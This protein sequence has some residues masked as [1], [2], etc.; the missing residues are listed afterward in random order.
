M[1][2]FL[3]YASLFLFCFLSASRDIYSE[4]VFKGPTE[5]D[6]IFAVFI[7]S[8]VTQIVALIVSVSDKIVRTFPNVVIRPRVS[9]TLVDLLYANIFTM[10]A[11]ITY[12]LAIRTS[13]GASLNAFVDYGC[14]PI[15]TGLVGG[16]LLKEPLQWHFGVASFISIIGVFILVERQG[17][18]LWNFS[19]VGFALAIVSCLCSVIYRISFKRLLQKQVK[20]ASIVFLRLIG[21]SVAAGLWL[22]FYGEKSYDVDDILSLVLTGVLGFAAPL[23]L[24]LYVLQR[25]SISRFGLFLFALPA[26]IYIEAVAFGLKQF[27]I[28]DCGAALMIFL[29]IWFHETGREKTSTLAHPSSTP[30]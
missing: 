21:T 5:V 23:F 30:R 11:F 10:G 28:I 9:E 15:L 29:G 26:I 16:V 8:I 4:R 3:L 27:S 17:Q 19:N 1:N 24:S 6:P 18:G 12:F 25:V 13:L 20:K 2:R 22:F 14:G 7:Y